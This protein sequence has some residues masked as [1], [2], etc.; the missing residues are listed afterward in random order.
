MR[1]GVFILFTCFSLS[2][3]GQVNVREALL[4]MPDTLCPY[5]HVSQRAQLMQ[6]AANGEIDSIPNLLMGKS[7]INKISDKAIKLHIANGIAFYLL[8][9]ND[10]IYLIQTV[11]APICSSTVRLYDKDWNLLT[12]IQAP[13]QGTFIEAI[14]EKD[15]I[16][17]KDNT[18]ELLDENEKQQYLEQIDSSI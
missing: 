9:K 6:L 5:L 15:S 18:P 11:C 8:T 14:I 1:K 7:T 12:N 4:T 3:M 13:I 17:Y 10:S 16:V 2:L